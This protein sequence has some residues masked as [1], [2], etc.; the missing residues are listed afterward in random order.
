MP[1]LFSLQS[2]KFLKHL[3][4]TELE[5]KRFL[6]ENWKHLFPHYTFISSEFRLKGN[7]RSKGSEGRIDIL[8]F[9]FETKKFVVFEL[10]KD[11]DKNVN[12]QASDYRDFIEDNFEKIYLQAIQTYSVELPKFTEVSQD[13]VEVVILSKSFSQT[14]I[15]RVKKRKNITLIKYVWF[16]DNLFLYDY[17]N[18]S[19][20]DENAEKIKTIKKVIDGKPI[21]SDVDM[22]FNVKQEA[23]RLFLMFKEFL[24][25]KG[26]TQIEVQQTK[27]KVKAQNGQTF[28]CIGYGG[29]TGRKYFLQVNTD[30]DVTQVLGLLV[31]DRIRPSGKK[32]GSIGSERYEV[33]I[34]NESQLYSLMN[35]IADKI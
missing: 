15:E 11:L 18:N 23:K 8:A 17:L 33:F 31:E 1:K 12:E 29:K 13:S 2:G 35:F 22:F 5:L 14:D 7:V 32:K 21:V 9:N 27:I 19:P 34:Q 20:D 28:S 26:D 3:N 30:I 4:K 24:E 25:T 10:K 6:T 16:E